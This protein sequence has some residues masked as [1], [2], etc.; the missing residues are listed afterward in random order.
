[1]SSRLSHAAQLAA[2]LDLE[3][4]SRRARYEGWV[5]CPQIKSWSMPGTI[6]PKSSL[7]LPEPGLYRYLI[8]IISTF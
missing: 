5:P 1:M 6:L 4:A 8:L 3:H 7:T 2:Y